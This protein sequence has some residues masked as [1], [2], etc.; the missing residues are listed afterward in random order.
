MRR[1]K[2]RL[3][4]RNN[5]LWILLKV[6]RSPF[7]NCN[8]KIIQGSSSTGKLFHCIQRWSF[9]SLLFQNL[10][11][12]SFVTSLP[13]PKHNLLQFSNR[14][15][16]F[17]WILLG[18]G[19]GL[20]PFLFPGLPFLLALNLAHARY[21]G[22]SGLFRAKALASALPS[23]FP[24]NYGNQSC[25]RSTRTRSWVLKRYYQSRRLFCQKL[26][27]GSSDLEQFLHDDILQNIWY[28][29]GCNYDTEKGVIH[30]YKSFNQPKT[31]AGSH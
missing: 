23:C 11:L 29:P 24:G 14:V 25:R 1:S 28:Q 10:M 21:F 7:C 12:L 2:K 4:K 17:C 19:L 16:G 8:I 27:E 18:M 9:H 6:K 30:G 13:N 5:L 22:R 3:I 31:K 26:E 15:N 20:G